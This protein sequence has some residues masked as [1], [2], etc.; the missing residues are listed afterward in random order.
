MT[1]PFVERRQAPRIAVSGGAWL[2]RPLVVS[3]RL[4]D[5]GRRGVLLLSPQPV[6]AGDFGHLTAR[7]GD[8]AIDGDIEVRR[9]SPQPGGHGSRVGARFVSLDPTTR[10]AVEQF[11]AAATR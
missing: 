10:S 7:V 4:L 5:I 8:I 9:V 1:E 11:L 6:D 2:D 3:V